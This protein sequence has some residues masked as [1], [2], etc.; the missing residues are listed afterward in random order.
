MAGHYNPAQR[1]GPDGRWIRTG[2]SGR[3]ISRAARSRTNKKAHA[4][5]RTVSTKILTIDKTASRRNRGVG[6]KG[7]EKNLIPYARISKRSATVGANTGTFIPFTNKR[8][9][10]GGFFKVEDARKKTAVDRIAQSAWN[11]VAPKGST[12]DLVGRHIA[13]HVKV[14]NPAI[15]YSA[16]GTNSRHGV[17]VRLGTSRKSGPTLTIRRGTHKRTQSESKSGIKR[18][19][20]QMS[21][22]QGKRVKESKPRPTRRRQA[23]RKR[24]ARR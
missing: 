8:I 1:R 18:Y 6:V 7:L 16:P 5:R 12:V 9:N 22:I 24:A 23:A 17:Q 21:K 2:A 10:F 4:A 19:D 3:R 20:K 13:K 11:S 14:D 15:R